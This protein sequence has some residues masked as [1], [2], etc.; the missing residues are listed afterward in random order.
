MKKQTKSLLGLMMGL[1]LMVIVPGAGL[2]PAAAEGLPVYDLPTRE[3]AVRET[4]QFYVNDEMVSEQFVVD[5]DY[6]YEPEVA[7]VDGKVF[8]GWVDEDG[9]SFDID[10]WESI[11]V[12]ETN[13]KKIYAN[14]EDAEIVAQF[15]YNTTVVDDESGEQVKKDVIVET[16]VA[17]EEGRVSLKDVNINLAI[18]EFL[19][20]WEM[21]GMTLSSDQTITISENKTLTAVVGKKVWVSYETGEGASVVPAV[22]LNPGATASKPSEP[23]RPGYRFV[24][25][26]KDGTKF[27]FTTPINEDTTITAEWEAVEVSYVVVVRRENPTSGEMK[28]VQVILDRKEKTGETVTILPTDSK[29]SFSDIDYYTPTATSFSGT[30][31]GDGSTIIYV[32]F[33][34]KEYTFEFEFGSNG[35]LQGARYVTYGSNTHWN[36]DKGNYIIKAKLGDDV[37]QVWAKSVGNIRGMLGLREYFYAWEA[38]N[39][40]SR[41]YFGGNLRTIT[42]EVLSATATTIHFRL[43]TGSIFDTPYQTRPSSWTPSA[44]V[45]EPTQPETP[46][47]PTF[48]VSFDLDGGSSEND[49]PAQTV[50]DGEYATAPSADPVKENY[51]FGGWKDKDSETAFDFGKVAIT[52]DTELVAVWVPVTEVVRVCYVDADGSEVYDE[53]LY[54]ENGTAVVREYAGNY[55]GG[56]YASFVGW[57]GTPATRGLTGGNL[58]QPNG[59][60]ELANY[61]RDGV[62]ELLAVLDLPEPTVDIV[63]FANNDTEDY[64]Y[65]D[66]IKKNGDYEILGIMFEKSGFKFVGWNTEEDGSGVMYQP[67]ELVALS[68]EN[69]NELYAIW[70][71]ITEEEPVEATSEVENPVTGDY[72]GI[73]GMTFIFSL[74]MLGAII[75]S[76]RT[77]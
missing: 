52:R 76:K 68:D 6:L 73:Y 22:A 39:L 35:F 2:V 34:R 9:N 11:S 31:A 5:G 36:Q 65:V 23:S 63:Y 60:I 32:D 54:T 77:A 48:S 51:V 59:L 61:A 15:V 66:G 7:P 58:F 41:P 13:T 53:L 56:F 49:F 47:T 20:G 55:D 37:S 1:S 12:S 72:I 62:V 43:V 75:F 19:K 10:F 3:E 69:W 27:D 38:T 16:R 71:E 8:T 29:I 30:I 18:D 26:Q 64:E 70:E 44:E 57:K 28:A 4:Y 42:P 67:G 33:E 17:D 24:E 25:W 45:S 40:P 14:F 21:D 50:S 74:M 46:D